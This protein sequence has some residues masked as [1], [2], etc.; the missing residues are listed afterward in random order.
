[1]T[2]C[3]SYFPKPVYLILLNL[4]LVSVLSASKAGP[5]KTSLLREGRRIEVMG[6]IDFSQAEFDEESGKRCI[7]KEVEVDTLNKEPIL[8]C[9]H[10]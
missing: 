4:L 2:H 10:K 9:T 5:Q 8:E 3:L 1:M 7:L 6:G